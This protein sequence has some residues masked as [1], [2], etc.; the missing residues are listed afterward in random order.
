MNFCVLIL[1]TKQPNSDNFK[2]AIRKTWALELKKNGV[3]YFFYEGDWGTNSIQDDVIKLDIEDEDNYSFKKLLLANSVLKN[4]NLN[5]DFIYK[6]NLYSYI[7]VPTFLK[8]IDLKAVNKPSY[9]G[10]I[11]KAYL[12]SQLTLKYKIFRK[13]ASKLNF[14][15]R[16]VFKHGSGFFIGEELLVQINETF[17]PIEDCQLADDIFIGILLS[18]IKVH[19]PK[20]LNMSIFANGSHKVVKKAYEINVEKGLLFH[21]RFRNENNET[22]VKTFESFQDFKTRLEICTYN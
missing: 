6:T 14:G 2:E 4:Q 19:E 15:K 13:F 1:S 3:D 5:Y 22:I 21:Y 7:D 20:C 17:A 8:F 10:L 12:L 18:H 11:T 16:I 9:I